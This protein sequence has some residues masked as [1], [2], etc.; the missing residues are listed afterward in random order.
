[1]KVVDKTAS[2]LL[3]R[4]FAMTPLDMPLFSSSSYKYRK[5]WDHLLQVLHLDKSL[6]L[7]PGGLRGG[8]AVF[9]Y[10]AGRPI[11][12]LLCL[13]R[14]R[15]QTILK[16]YLQEVSALNIL[17][18]PLPNTK[19]NVKLFAASF[20]F[21]GSGD[22]LLQYDI[23][24]TA[25]TRTKKQWKDLATPKEKERA[26][27][28]AKA[29]AKAKLTLAAKKAAEEEKA[30]KEAEEKAAEAAYKKRLREQRRL[31]T[32][33]QKKNKKRR[34]RGRAKADKKREKRKEAREQPE[35]SDAHQKYK[36]GLTEN[37][38]VKRQKTAEERRGP[39]G[40]KVFFL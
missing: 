2:Q 6:K 19:A 11:E 28:Q 39:Q 15:S 22:R 14:L 37:S 10:K 12:D 33:K 9:H 5:R 20:G 16:S 31:R 29:A 23:D 25:R 40:N 26:E 34:E 4:I 32:E 1:M 24:E 18:K 17:A 3:S 7:T 30:K 38:L 36:T 35:A 8:A 21:L 27:K 13:L